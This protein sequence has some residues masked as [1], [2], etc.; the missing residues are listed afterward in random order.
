MRHRLALGSPRILAGLGAITLPLHLLEAFLEI[1]DAFL[2]KHQLVC[3]ERI[4][5]SVPRRRLGV[6]LR[7]LGVRDGDWKDASQFRPVDQ[8]GVVVIL[9]AGNGAAFDRTST[10]RWPS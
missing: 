2:G 6:R 7:G 3:G 10:P 9:G 8:P 5:V 1:G 4:G